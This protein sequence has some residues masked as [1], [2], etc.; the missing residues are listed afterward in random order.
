MPFDNLNM[1]LARDFV[2]PHGTDPVLETLV[3]ARALIADPSKWAKKASSGD[4]HCAG[5]A[6]FT[7]GGADGG[8]P[9]DRAWDFLETFVPDGLCLPTYNDAPATTHAD[10]LA[11]FDRAIASRL[12][13]AEA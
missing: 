11:L 9:G 1:P 8:S 4:A 6:C 7:A 3:A 2:A 13:K 10:V 12:S 5:L